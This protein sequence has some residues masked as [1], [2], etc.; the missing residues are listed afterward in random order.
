[1]TVQPFRFGVQ[2]YGAADAK[3]WREQV[4]RAVDLGYHSVH[5]PDHLGGQFS[6]LLAL[7]S[8][9]AAHP[10]LRIGTLV[11]NCALRHPAVLAK[12]LATLDVLSDG[13]LEAG[14]GAGWMATDFQRSGTDRLDPAGRVRRLAEY[15]G[16]LERLWSGEEV[17]HRGAYLRLEGAVCLPRPVQP[18]LPLLIGGGSPRILRFA[19]AHAQTVGLDVPQ[20][21]GRFDKPTYLRAAGRAAFLERAGWA[22]DAAAGAGRAVTLQMQIPS[23]LLHLDGEP[24][25]EVARRWDVPPDVVRDTPLALVGPVDDVMERLRRWRAGSGVSYLVVP[26]DAM[27]AAAPLVERLAG[28]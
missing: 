12:E 15:V 8:A 7:G 1:M 28:R 6:P 5:L 22:R 27:A 11:L 21:A 4:S 14:I 26:A 10:H 18:R 9:A 23:D 25:E 24:V 19:G 3:S 17:T 2:L 16:V 13:R 20:P